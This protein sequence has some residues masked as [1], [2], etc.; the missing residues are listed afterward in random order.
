M[1]D[2]VKRRGKYTEGESRY[3]MT[4]ILTGCQHMHLN[5][6]IH[7]DLKLG[8]IFLDSRM[9]VKIGDFGLAA[10]LNFPEE[11]KKTV[12]GTPNYIA[13]EI[14][15]DQGEGHSF[16]VDIWS[17][18]VILYTLL[19]GKPPFQTN[20]V[21]KIYEK[22]KRNEYEIPADSTISDSARELIQSILT[23]DPS[24]RP[25][26]IEIMNHRW[27][28]DGLVPLTVP[29]IATRQEPMLPLLSPEQS[30]ANFAKLKENGGWIPDADDLLDDEED[31]EEE[32]EEDG[33][34]QDDALE[35]EAAAASKV[36]AQQAARLRELESM[37]EQRA[38]CNREAERAVQPGSPI[39]TLLRVAQKPLIKV[40][41]ATAPAPSAGRTSAATST[42]SLARQLGALS[43]S[44]Q[45]QRGG[46][47]ADKENVVGM[48]PPQNS[49]RSTRSSAATLHEDP[50]ED[51]RALTQKAR[52]LAGINAT[53]GSAVS[54]ASADSGSMRGGAGSNS[55]VRA[56]N[57]HWSEL[58]INRLD[59]AMAA[60]DANRLLTLHGVEMPVL[61]RRE[62]EDKTV[63]RVPPA[64]K[65]F[66][67][68]WLDASERY[69]LGYA[70]SNGSIGVKYRDN[71]SLILAP[72]ERVFE[73]ITPVKRSSTQAE[74]APSN[75]C[76][77]YDLP[78]NL[79][80]QA[81]DFREQLSQLMPEPVVSKLEIMHY[82]KAEINDRL[83]GGDHPFLRR[84][85]S[86]TRELSHLAKWS[87]GTNAIVF[88][89]S[90]DTL[91]F[92]FYDHF[93]IFI[94]DHGLS[95]GALVPSEVV[96]GKQV[97]YT[98]SLTELVSI[99]LKDRSQREAAAWIEYEQRPDLELPAVDQTT[100][101]ERKV[102]RRLVRKLKI[103]KEAIIAS[104]SSARP[105][106][107]RTPS[108]ASLGS[109]GSAVRATRAAR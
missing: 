19:I 14:L 101:E 36:R 48:L 57:A 5:S 67:I 4:Q 23:P 40:A 64:P 3:F 32:E 84:D 77:R 28:A 15:Y 61:E 62:S 24:M 11:R 37:E 51:R 7:R 2:I 63:R 100:A 12:C 106:M 42:S 53:A 86:L 6:V 22:I 99:A 16:E 39:S 69:G 82:F 46:A 87:R 80:P 58:I 94:M 103:C 68:S 85:P 81:A 89:F 54:I 97:L 91:Q 55:K 41:G 107:S 25:T 27:F 83:C 50:T 8:N 38:A 79:D 90:D 92:N 70:L 31:D 109:N 35:G 30:E 102:V 74:A 47:T 17:V 44:R 56:S 18:G 65:S 45:Q 52:L 75:Q 59:A 73:Y 20:N 88:Q 72:N 96:P 26:L 66:I 10:L 33:G 60:C 34:A 93:K 104:H 49:A 43:V 29:A 105:A 78:S 21:E 76:K 9:N 98:W 13:P 71:C 1:N 95:I 108:V